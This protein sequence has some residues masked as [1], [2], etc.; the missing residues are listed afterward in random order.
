MTSAGDPAAS[1]RRLLF[2]H[3]PKTAG[4]SLRTFLERQY[5][6]QD[7]L[8]AVSWTEYAARGLR[9]ADYALFNGHFRFNFRQVVPPGTRLFTALRDPV[10][11]Y[12]SALRHARRDPAFDPRHAALNAMPLADVIRHPEFSVQRA[13]V[14]THWLA[15]S[16]S[17]ATVAAYLAARPQ[18]DQADVEMRPPPDELLQTA[19]AHLEE[20]DFI[21]FAEDL[22]GVIDEVCGAMQFHPPAAQPVKNVGRGDSD[23]P[24]ELRP[25]D[26]AVIRRLTELDGEL[27][28]YAWHLSQR[29]RRSRGFVDQGVRL[30]LRGHAAAFNEVEIEPGTT[31]H[32]G[33]ADLR[34]R[35]MI[36][37]WAEPEEHHN[38]NDGAEVEFAIACRAPVRRLL[39]EVVGQPYISAK[40]PSQPLIVHGNGLRIFT[41]QLSVP[42]ET[43]LLIPL[44]PQW[45]SVEGGKARLRLRFHLPQSAS[46]KSL[47]EGGDERSLAFL[48]QTI[49][50]RD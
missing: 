4:T 41:A 33:A 1:G 30:G 39:L 6:P 32:F 5:A 34:S 8:P 15:A 20:I 16:A 18:G 9:A 25:D 7:I 49:G 38:W 50:L 10:A 13:N 46:P 21:G 48:F 28:A 37:G 12:I 29:R 19:I 43:R 35:G 2:L 31:R 26:I 44:L 45:W 27:Y 24:G 42:A 11:Q 3:I 47:G 14:Q 36:G 23:P 17:A 22:P 40:R